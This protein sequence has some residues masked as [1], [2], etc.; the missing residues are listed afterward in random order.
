[1]N[2]AEEVIGVPLSRT[3]STRAE[4]LVWVGV[5]FVSFRVANAEPALRPLMLFYVFGMCRLAWRVSVR[6]GFYFGVFAGFLCF[7]S[8][9]TFFWRIFGP[10]AIVLWL[11]LAFWSGS[12]VGLLSWVR[13]GWGRVAFVASAP[14][15]WLGLEYFRSELY[16]LRFAWSTAGAGLV[17]FGVWGMAGLGA[18]GAGALLALVASWLCSGRLRH[19]LVG[20][21]VAV[22]ILSVGRFD[23]SEE[24]AIDSG[25][26]IGGVQLEFPSRSTILSALDRLVFLHPE[27]D[28][29]VLSEYSLA[30][31]PTP[32]IKRW[33]L[34]H[35]KFLAI[36]GKD[37][38]GDG[39]YYNTVFVVGPEGETVFKQAKS[40]PIQFFD[41]GE[42][43]PN[44]RVWN[45]PWG[46]IGF[47]ICYDL[48]FT[49]VMDELVRQGAQLL[50][51]PTMDVEEWGAREHALH[52]RIAPLRAAEYQV[53]IFRLASSGISQSVDARGV[54]KCEAPF[55]GQGEV[56]YDEIALVAAG[57]LP[58][59][60]Y[61][62]PVAS[63]LVGCLVIVCLFASRNPKR[64]T[65]EN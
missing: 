55:P 15:V 48:S 24:G 43:A 12:S 30:T 45:S 13:Q 2:V 23:T 40:A 46:K 9:L 26:R 8:E 52:A 42:P 3:R 27:I 49:R 50:V 31:K 1:M 44:Q 10:A 14:V 7:A 36:G 33:C 16:A 32:E 37:S 28:L 34:E 53:P 65:R 22:A 6:E 35:G 18:Y 41:D 17:E 54:V 63:C 39:S 29:I 60:R 38:Q 51:V 4:L 25:I 47:A 19:G 20:A 58:V 5:S 59:D 56:L 64:G 11:V 61:L 21:F 62:G 57:R